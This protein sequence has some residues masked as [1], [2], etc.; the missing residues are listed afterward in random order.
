MIRDLFDAMAHNGWALAGAVILAAL[1]G[2]LIACVM[3]GRRT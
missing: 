2:G 1:V 3:P